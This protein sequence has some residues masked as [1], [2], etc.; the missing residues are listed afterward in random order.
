[1]IFANFEMHGETDLRRFAQTIEVS[2]VTA[3]SQSARNYKVDT[4]SYISAT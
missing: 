1:M 2:S 3:N 4:R